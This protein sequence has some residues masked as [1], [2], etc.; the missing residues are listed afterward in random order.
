VS[1]LGTDRGG[2]RRWCIRQGEFSERGLRGREKCRRGAA[3][4]EGIECGQPGEEIGVLGGRDGARQGLIEV[5]V[6]V[7]EA[8]QDEVTLRSSTASAV[9][10]VHAS[11]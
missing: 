11:R 3:R 4:P 1:R 10:E 2:P 9:E 8:W 6:R 7:D 5:M